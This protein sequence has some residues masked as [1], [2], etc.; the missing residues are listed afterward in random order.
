[1]A[2]RSTPH[3]R[4]YGRFGD[5]DPALLAQLSIEHHKSGLTPLAAFHPSVGLPYSTQ[6]ELDSWNEIQTYQRL[7]LYGFTTRDLINQEVITNGA[8][9]LDTLDNPIMPLLNMDRWEETAE[10]SFN[11]SLYP[12][13]NGHGDWIYKNHIIKPHLEKVLRLVTLLLLNLHKHP[14]VCLP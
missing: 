11:R 10:P 14:W 3:S 7:K 8:L 1:M 2:N 9:P 4:K 5:E 6:A 12:L 13:K